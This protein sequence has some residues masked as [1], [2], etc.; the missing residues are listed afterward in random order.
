M[1]LV[2][3]WPLPVWNHS[4][5]VDSERNAIDR[6][7]WLFVAFVVVIIAIGGLIAYNGNITLFV[8]TVVHKAGPAG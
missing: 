3:S 8:T 1:V 7:G 5:Q 6:L 4:R 2:A